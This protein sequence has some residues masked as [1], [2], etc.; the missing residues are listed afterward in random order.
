MELLLAEIRRKRLLID[1]P[2]FLASLQARLMAL[3]PNP[4]IT[5][6]QVEMLKSDNIVATGAL[7]FS[8]LGIVPNTVEAILPTYLDRFRRGGW[9]ESRQRAA[10]T[11]TRK[12]R[13]RRKTPS[14]STSPPAGSSSNCGPIWPRITAPISRRWRGAGFTTASCSTG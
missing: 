10:S 11:L 5:P 6:D 3:L 4:P 9:Y 1:L 14:I 8:A 12:G 2:F 13:H 7:G